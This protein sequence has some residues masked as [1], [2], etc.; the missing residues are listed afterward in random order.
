MFGRFYHFYYVHRQLCVEDL[1]QKRSQD[2]RLQ[3][4]IAERIKPIGEVKVAE[5]GEFK[6]RLKQWKIQN[7]K[8]FKLK[9]P[10]PVTPTSSAYRAASAGKG[11]EVY[12]TACLACHI[13]GA[14]GAQYLAIRLPGLTAWRKVLMHCMRMRSM[15]RARCQRVGG[16]PRFGC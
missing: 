4:A 14:V 11:K 9:S 1:N 7:P 5:A 10:A 6:L 3:A 16:W 12:N 15:A 2:S 8:S 13:S